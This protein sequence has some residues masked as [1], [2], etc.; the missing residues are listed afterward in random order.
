M[1]AVLHG[2]YDQHL[3][4]IRLRQVWCR[5]ATLPRKSLLERL[6]KRRTILVYALLL[7]ASHI[8]TFLIPESW[9]RL[10]S[11]EFKHQTT[12]IPALDESSSPFEAT[13]GYLE[14]SA[15]DHSR[16]LPAVLLL[17]GS[18]GQSADWVRVA[19]RVQAAGY[20]VIAVD[21]PGFNESTALVPDYS[22]KA[23]AKAIDVFMDGLGINRAHVVGWS[24]GGGVALHLADDSPS[25]VVSLTLLSSIGAQE[26]EGSGSYFFEHV[27]YAAAYGL[28][29][30]VPE[31][32]PHFGLL[33]PRQMRHAF[34]RTFW[35][36]DQRPLRGIMERIG[37]PTMILHGRRDVLVPARVAE[38]HHRIIKR[39][40]L[41]M[42]DANHFIPFTHAA[43]AADRL[44]AFFRKHDK[45]GTAPTPSLKDVRLNRPIDAF[46]SIVSNVRM[47]VLDARWFVE[48][49]LIVLGFFVLPRSTLT[50]SALL[51][52]GLDLD[53]GVFIAGWICVLW[54]QALAGVCLARVLPDI[55]PVGKNR[56]RQSR[57]SMT[58]WQQ[59]LARSPFEV[60]WKSHFIPH[61]RAP[62]CAAVGSC[63]RSGAATL[64]A[65]CAFLLGR[66]S[67]AAVSASA[68]LVT[69]IALSIAYGSIVGEQSHFMASIGW[70][71]VAAFSVLF[72][73]LFISRRGR[74]YLAARFGRLLHHEY[75]PTWAF[76]APLVPY[77]AY[78]AVKHR[79]LMLPTLVNPGIPN[80]GGIAGESKFEIMSRL[81][82]LLGLSLPTFLIPAMERPEQR[83][84]LVRSII[85]HE[86]GLEDY[87]I[88]AKPNAGERGH[89][90]KL[91]R[92]ET[93]L[94]DYF[95]QMPADAVVQP[96]HPGPHECGVLWIRD[97]FQS[98]GDTTPHQTY[99]P[100]TSEVRNSP[101]GRVYSMTR[102]EFPAI[103]GDGRS[104]IEDLILDHPRY[105]RQAS[106]FLARF[107][108]DCMRVPDEGEVVR[109]AV[110]GNHCQGT[111]FRD[112]ADLI[113]PR[114]QAT[115]DKLASTFPGLD[116]GR[117]DIR[118][119]HED[120]LRNGRGF[121][122]VELNGTSSEPTN[123]YDPDRSLFFAYRVLFGAWKRLFE[124]GAARRSEGRTPVS[125]IQVL[126]FLRHHRNAQ[127]GPALAD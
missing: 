79:G 118:Y 32:V 86:A 59:T 37:Q 96:F 19:P 100:A 38:D 69:L 56:I 89:A 61:S 17:H 126:S 55:S 73:P 104:T 111:L 9:F 110:S 63:L 117:F 80:A 112:G 82:R 76:Y 10:P 75:W 18:P 98:E 77:I 4:G 45:P 119:E 71:A 47:M 53:F 107:A 87:P 97:S 85:N 41:E 78:L 114:L 13:L 90:V 51:V 70:I 2:R 64:G 66:A 26:N 1:T 123:M 31:L 22:I 84:S 15:P 81:D 36:S 113:T 99:Q 125:L 29:V 94:I 121:R 91:I 12:L 7:I 23:H 93:E 83:A 8:V 95:E 101:I 116:F 3:Q 105:R 92:S 109:L 102:K 49:M 108:D 58:H 88:I 30:I 106:V 21:L 16:K 11:H 68:G 122:V 65:A 124:L 40:S 6:G 54:L 67:A 42:L 60:G 27:K 72:A 103:T 28:F 39:S 35:D 57:P 62:A 115:I 20:R 25:R 5:L 43:E 74:S 46:S 48:F 14:W 52:V 50:A 120:D 24:N 34:A 127:R 33:G 44:I